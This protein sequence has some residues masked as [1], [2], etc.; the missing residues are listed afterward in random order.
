MFY[1]FLHPGT[2]RCIYTDSKYPIPGNT[3]VLCANS[4]Y[5]PD[6]LSHCGSNLLVCSA[7]GQTVTAE[8][9]TDQPGFT[10]MPSPTPASQAAS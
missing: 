4:L 7:D 1:Y 3:T 2:S 6:G 8:V 10:M 9:Y 5:Y